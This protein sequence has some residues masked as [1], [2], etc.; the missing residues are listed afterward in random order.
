M[1]KQLLGLITILTVLASCQK[2]GVSVE[3]SEAVTIHA[4]IDDA[5][6]TRTVMDENN[7]VL[8]SE[9][10]QIIAFLKS[11]FGHKYQVKPSFIGKSYAEF[12]MI[13]TGAGNDLF[14]GNEW[15]HNVAYYP[16]SEDIECLKS[17]S[18]YEIKVNLPSEQAYVPD[19][20]ANGSMAMVAI[21]ENNNITFRNVLGGIKL[22]LKG[23]QK[24]TSI[25][26][27]GKNNEKLSGAAVV[28][29]HTDGN[30]PAITM[31]LSAS[32]SVALNCGDGVQLNESTATEFIFA[33]PPVLFSKGFTVT[34]TD[35]NANEQTIGTDK[36]N[37]VLRSSLII[38]PEVKL[39]QPGD[40]VDEYGINHGQGVK[41]GETVWAPV[42]CGYHKTDFK[43]GK[44]YQWGRKYGQ[45]YNG[46]FYDGDW[47]QDYSDGILPEFIYGNGNISIEEGQSE[48]YSNVFFR[49]GNMDW[50]W[51]YPHD[52]TLWNKGTDDTPQKDT[53]NDPCPQGWRV[54]SY[55]EY[56]ALIRN[57]SS[58]TSDKDGIN[59][60]YFSGLASYSQ[61]VSQIFL[62]AAGSRVYYDEA[63]GYNRGGGGRYWSSRS[64]GE[65]DNLAYY[66]YFNRSEVYWDLYD[67]A[68]GY[69]VRCVKE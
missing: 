64:G 59:G 41:I 9:N 50:D 2:N 4:T 53:N 57:H 1:K 34:V 19:S 3:L 68:L 44:L 14:A 36:E 32:K 5:D 15:E 46:E 60:Y 28:T 51:V 55:T 37:A 11:S 40:Y 8:W 35:A 16:Y 26:I 23:T 29:A 65:S 7:N 12:S 20:F 27:E 13:S 69:S 54:P 56:D 45:G 18:N 52:G 30:K 10:D 62:P 63:Y 38:M 25:K 61:D 31:A 24:V 43:Y 17:G 48:K 39:A 67:R 21:S 49:G 22:Q 42:N 33:M 66:I 58:F 6:V 47:N